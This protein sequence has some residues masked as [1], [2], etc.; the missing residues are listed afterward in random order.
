M[1][2]SISA[3]DFECGYSVFSKHGESWKEKKRLYLCISEK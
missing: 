3:E 1:A 2:F